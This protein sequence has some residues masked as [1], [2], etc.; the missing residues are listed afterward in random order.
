MLLDHIG[1][2]FSSQLTA[3]VWG[4]VL[5]TVFRVLGRLTAPIMCFFL[6]QGF[7]Y[8]HSKKQYAI[9]LAIFALLSQ[10][11]YALARKHSLLTP[12]F[13]MIFVL[14]ISFAILCIWESRL[15]NVPKIV[16][17][18]IL[19]CLSLFCDWGLFAPLMVLFFYVFRADHKN[20]IM[21]Y[22]LLAILVN[23][24]SCLI[25]PMNGFAWYT[26]LWQLGLFLFIPLLFIYNGQ[27]GSRAA[28]H[29]WFFY[30]FYPAHLLLLWGLSKA[31]F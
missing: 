15:E 6:V 2:I 9:R 1:M 10:I 31:I 14:L 7:I 27:P 26:E 22:C 18:V 11:P 16:L 21:T 5:Y 30:I 23:I 24:M 4:S 13:N 12:D 8:T 20:Q 19:T 3:T 25:L 28:F 29:K 17:L